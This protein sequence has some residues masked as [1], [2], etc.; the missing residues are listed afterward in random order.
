MNRMRMLMVVVR[1]QRCLSAGLTSS[2]A[3]TASTPYSQNAF[4]IPRQHVWRQM[5]RWSYAPSASTV[6]PRAAAAAQTM[7]ISTAAPSISGSHPVVHRTGLLPSGKQQQHGNRLYSIGQRRFSSF[8]SVGPPPPQFPWVGA[9][10]IVG[11]SALAV[12]I[13]FFIGKFILIGFLMLGGILLLMK[14]TRSSSMGRQLSRRVGINPDSLTGRQILSS[15]VDSAMIVCD[16][17]VVVVV[18]IH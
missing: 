13:L 8:R 6:R 1:R 5:P 11:V 16:N 18:F 2:T 12:F 9:M 7:S 3:A 15:I 10:I 14:G 4:Q 17:F